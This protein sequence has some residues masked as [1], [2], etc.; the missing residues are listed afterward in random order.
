MAKRYLTLKPRV[1]S[2]ERPFHASIQT[3]YKKAEKE[4][5]LA[6]IQPKLL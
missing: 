4:R 3:N 2:N 6:K 1:K 5:Q